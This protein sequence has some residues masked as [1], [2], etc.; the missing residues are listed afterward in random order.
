[1]FKVI[2]RLRDLVILWDGA[3][4]SSHYSECNFK[5]AGC[6]VQKTHNSFMK[7]PLRVFLCIFQT[8]EMEVSVIVEILTCHHHASLTKCVNLLTRFLSNYWFIAK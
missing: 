3:L 5:H 1:M 4:V 6:S 7:E 2:I 8:S